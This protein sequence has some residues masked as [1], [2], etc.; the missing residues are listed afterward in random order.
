MHTQDMPQHA[1]AGHDASAE[2]LTG[3]S[4][5]AVLAGATAAAALSFVLL[6][7]GIGLGLSAMSPY[8]YNAT[9]LTGATIGWI[10]FMQLAASALGGYLA[11]RL[12]R[13]WLRTH[14]DEV[15]FRDT[16]HGLLAWA[17][18]TLLSVALLASGI[19]TALGGALDAGTAAATV[20]AP[21]IAADMNGPGRSGYFTDMLLRS[22]TA[23]PATE[24]QRAEI[25]RIVA[26]SVADGKLAAD[27]RSYLAQLVAA[28]TGLPQADA[29]RRVDAIVAQ[30]AAAA[31]QAK[32]KAQE[33]ADHA[34]KA[35]AHSALWMFV[36]LLA[37]A[38]VA[39]LAATVGGRQR[40]DIRVHSF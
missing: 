3:L 5:G 11:G 2:T 30:A 33:M 1:M 14:G 23:A 31:S 28:R 34:R 12:R 7:L 9:P 21:A 13:R 6:L 36:A 38:F 16:A 22:G 24:P 4:W 8:A 39:S 10:A 37:G 18:A 40:D 25:T 19:K 32:A 29:E 15:Y 26:A 27:D 17:V 35:G 20:A